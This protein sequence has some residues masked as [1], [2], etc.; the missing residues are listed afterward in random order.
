MRF[1]LSLHLSMTLHF[2]RNSLRKNEHFPLVLM[3]EPTHRCNLACAGCDRIRLY[4]KNEVPDLGLDECLDAA[5]QSQA[6]VVTV[7][8]G[9]PLLY[10]QVKP[11]V[12]ELL[13][14]KR[15]VY[16]CTNGLLAEDF[17]ASV[18]PHPRFVLNFHLDGMAETHDRIARRPGTFERAVENIKRAKARGYRVNTNTTVFKDSDIGDLRGLFELLKGLGVDG[19]L[20]SPAFSYESVEDCIFLSRQEIV[21]KFRQMEGFFSAFSFL[22][23]PPYV[24]FLLGKRELRCTPWGIPTRNPLGW[25]SPCYFI[26]DRYVGSFQELMQETDWRRFEEGEDPRCRNCM[27]HGGYEAS[28]MRLV[29][30]SP[31]D[32]VRLAL[33]NMS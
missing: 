30:S 29:S 25:K 23:T 13:A 14:M 2:L 5:V 22:S 4:G 10:S 28:V 16:L 3:L 33:W 11:L 17:I 12:R 26:T 9:E 21:E 6:P 27:V 19:S 24:D 18:E 7:T 20:I 15:H 8:G 32:L 31:R 1:P